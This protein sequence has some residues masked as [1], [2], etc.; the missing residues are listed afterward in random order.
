MIRARRH[1][2]VAA[3]GAFGLLAVVAELVGRVLVDQLDFGRHVGT[4]SYA[5]A[6]YYPFLLGAVKLGIALLL[7]RLAWRFV[8][9]RATARAG[10]RMLARVGRPQPLRVPRLR[11]QLSPRL[12]LAS[13]GLTSSVYLVHADAEGISS[14]H[15]QLLS[16]V[17]HTSA[18]PVFAVLSVLVALAW[19]LVA[20]WLAE[21]ESYAEAMLAHAHRIAGAEPADP[22]GESVSR[23]PRLLFG[24]ALESRAPPLAA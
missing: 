3:A 18:L 2:R 5:G 13:F 11:F 23:P 12:W 17:L 6:G 19:K 8:R 10:R 1:P 4:P 14:G 21:Y 16:P 7:A 9:A 15:W 20:G 24:H 22:P